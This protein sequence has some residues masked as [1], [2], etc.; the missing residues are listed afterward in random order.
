MRSGSTNTGATPNSEARLRLMLAEE[1][2][3][4]S[5]EGLAR[6]CMVYIAKILNGDEKGVRPRTRLRAAVDGL[7]IL[8]KFSGLSAQ[9]V[10][11]TGAPDGAPVK[12]SIV[13]LLR[14]AVPEP[15]APARKR[16]AGQKH[17]TET[18]RKRRGRP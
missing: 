15:A 2:I 8:G 11:V 17:A 1:A 13:D 9:R 5:D 6:A 7:R 3:R 14:E 10:E 4:A 12:V 18:G 16:P